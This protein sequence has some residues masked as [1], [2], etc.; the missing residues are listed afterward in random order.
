MT[1]VR[2]LCP[3]VFQVLATL[4]AH[5]NSISVGLCQGYSAILLPQLQDKGS[6]LVVSEQDA[7]WIGESVTVTSPC[8]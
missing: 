8:Q 3:L 5:S 1:P 2:S 4:A 6:K 7:S